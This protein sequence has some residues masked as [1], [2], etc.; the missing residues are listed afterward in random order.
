M[1][2]KKADYRDFKKRATTSV[3]NEDP[4]GEEQASSPRHAGNI[5][6]WPDADGAPLSEGVSPT[7]RGD[8]LNLSIGR[9]DEE[10][11]KP[12]LI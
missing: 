1:K 6:E 3:I 4:L 7:S 2:A 5:D 12:Q 9:D 10:D 11:S 8:A